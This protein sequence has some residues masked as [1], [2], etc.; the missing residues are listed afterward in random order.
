MSERQTY[1]GIDGCK[2]GWI[3]FTLS[4]L[5]EQAQIRMFE[6]ISALWMK[7]REDEPVRGVLDA[8]D[9]EEA[10][11][12]NRQLGERGLS[13]Q[14]WFLVPKIRELD[15]LLRSKEAA[16][17]K[18]REAHP[19]VCFAALFGAP[20]KY[21]KKTED[22]FRERMDHLLTVYP[23]AAKV[24]EAA[25]KLYPRSAAVRDDFVDALVLAVSGA[26]SKGELKSVPA[27]PE[28]DMHGLSMAIWYAKQRY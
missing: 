10:N 13:K 23:E 22:G 1:A 19:E 15:S 18:L 27:Q 20:M 28:K 26:I 25:M 3:A 7:L 17:C 12:M 4:D 24:I 11:A 14:T 21:N 9:Y 16:A 2:A 5:S 8:C 6:S